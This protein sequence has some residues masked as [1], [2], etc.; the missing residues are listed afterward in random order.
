M[1]LH[2]YDGVIRRARA[3][4]EVLM[5]EGIIPPVP[6]TIESADRASGAAHGL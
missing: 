6:T 5:R 2:A 4:T 3:G 1:R